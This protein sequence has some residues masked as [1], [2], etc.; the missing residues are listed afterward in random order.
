[1][2]NGSYRGADNYSHRQHMQKQHGEKFSLLLTPD[3][4]MQK[5]MVKKFLTPE[6]QRGFTE[7][8]RTITTDN[9]CKNNLMKNLL[10]PEF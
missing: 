7:E 5:N 3:S 4:E 10:T 8:Q 1:M 2:S 9:T 6:S